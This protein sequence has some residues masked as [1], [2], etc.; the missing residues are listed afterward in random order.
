MIKPLSVILMWHMHQPQYKDPVSGEYILPW[1]YLHAVKDY[2]DMAAIVDEVEGARAVFNFVP[3]LLE[4][5]EDYAAGTAIDPFLIHG[6]MDP[7]TMSDDERLFVVNNFFAAN[8]Q[9][10][11]EPNRRYAEL[12]RLAG[13]NPAEDSARLLRQFR[14]QEILDLQVCFFL[15]WTGEAARR[16]FPELQELVAKERGYTFQE[17]S[18]LFNIHSRILKSIIPL[19][20][21]LHREGKIELTVT[22]YF[23]PIMPLLCDTRI[24]SV[25][26]PR[27]HLPERHL[28]CPEDA[29]SQIM[30]GIACFER[31]FGFRPSGCWPSEGSVS[32]QVLTIMAESGISWAATDEGIL[33]ASIGGLGIGREALYHPYLYSS[34][35][36]EIALFFRDHTLSD[37]VGF[38]Y[39]QW[40]EQK[41]VA[42]FID[43]LRHI[44]LTQPDATSVSVI[45]DG[46][47]AWEYYPDN[48]YHFLKA[49]YEA[50]SVSHEIH[51]AT[52][53]EILASSEPRR[54]N[55]I[56]PGSWINSNYGIWIGHPEENTGW[57]LIAMAREAAV[58]KSPQLAA[59]LAA[60]VDDLEKIEDPLLA[61]VC[62]DLFAAQGSD[63]FWWYGDDHFTSHGEQFDLLFRRHL[64]NIYRS[65]EMDI[66]AELY[67]PIKKKSPAGFIRTPSA[68][69]EPEI[70]GQAGD[71]FEWLAAGLYDLSRQSSAMHSAQTSLRLF[72]YG[73]D[74]KNLYF[75]IDAEGS[76]ERFIKHDDILVL[77]LTLEAEYRM[78]MTAETQAVP[79]Q[80]RADGIWQDLD[81]SC[82]FALK[83]IC[84]IALPIKPLNLSAGDYIFVGLVHLRDSSEIG[85][86]PADAPMKLLYAGGE[87]E[88]DTWLI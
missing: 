15:A 74:S 16:R 55:H 87:L 75:R 40:E 33:S 61:S 4:Q 2:Y 66:P 70:T 69:I 79:L 44:G 38:T 42:D 26:M 62:R 30:T 73:F 23:H 58:R 29:R 24:A 27:A 13:D 7:S 76:L 3:S 71:Y 49:L 35:G 60:G 41:A 10:L 17:K 28:A 53:T 25:A 18:L 1:T 81:A 56:H 11:I 84:E 65:L 47:N 43:R 54:L 72:Y 34:G 63:W 86:W 22:P 19:Y 68:F 64:M 9:R 50:L 5:L 14:Y 39:S 8:R 32:D 36:D 83:K 51:A 82:S 6:K 80:T 88:L 48:G 85:R 59:L 31:L 52:C 21:K 45:L 46:E 67:K 37:L 57:D 12:H 20:R 78:V 77:Y